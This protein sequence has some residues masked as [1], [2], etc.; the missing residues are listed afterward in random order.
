MFDSAM[1]GT[2]DLGEERERADDGHH[3]L[4][5]R[6]PSARRRDGR[7]EL[8]VADG[9]LERPAGDAAARVDVVGV[10]VG[11]VGDVL[12]GR[13]GGV[14]RGHGHDLDRIAGRRCGGSLGG[15][16]CGRF[17]A[18]FCARFSRRLGR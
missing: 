12:V 3:A 6:L 2:I 8:L 14:E 5:D 13:A 11:G 16:R 1:T 17:C 4:F 10:R 18:R 9:D 7:V 15:A